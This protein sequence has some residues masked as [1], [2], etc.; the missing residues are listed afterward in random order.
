MKEEKNKEKKLRILAA[1]DL[2]GDTNLVKKLAERAKKENV[3]LVILAGDLTFADTQTKNLIGPFVKAGKKVLLVPGNH[4]TMATTDF[5]AEL[6]PNTHNMHGYS[7]KIKDV[8][9]FG[10]GGADIGIT[11]VSEKEMME[12]LNR[13][14]EGIKDLKKKIMITHM[15]P[16]SS[17][18]EMS[19]FE[20][21]VSIKKAI[22]KFKPDL[23]IH[24]HIHEAEGIEDKIGKTKILNVGRRGR[25]IEL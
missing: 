21:S 1:G 4:E 12:T 15:H 2:H 24:S 5:L 23:L 16:Q 6:Y 19:G 20:G 3:D 25:I 8:G 9:I 7:M 11:V 13:A 18:S 22:E 14:H 10:A 17:A